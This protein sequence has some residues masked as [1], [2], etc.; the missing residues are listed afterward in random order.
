MNEQKLKELLHLYVLGELTGKEKEIIENHL[1][2]SDEYKEEYE[3]LKKFYETVSA[4]KPAKVADSLLFEA[5]AGLR[6]KLTGME[7]KE[8]LFA[9]IGEGLTNFFTAPF[10]PAYSAAL[11]L[12]LGLF[13]GYFMFSSSPRVDVLPQQEG[14]E[15]NLDEIERSGMNISN[16]R[17]R[18]SF[19]NGGDIEI[20]FDA[21]KPISMKGNMEDVRI[22]RLLAAALT[23]SENDGVRIRTVNTIASR[24]NENFIA[25][26][27]IKVALIMAL[28]TDKNVGVRREAL[29]T[30]KK[31]PYDTELRDAYLFALTNDTNPGIKVAA[32]NALAELKMQGKSIDNE[33]K[34]VLENE[35][36]DGQEDYIKLRAASLI[37]EV[38]QNE[39]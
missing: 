25:D 4:N 22:Q 15:V 11:T 14:K 36:D 38:K 9:K 35:F 16:I 10:A 21:I 13:I 23:S 1:L 5:R 2:E 33:L 20:T 6:R 29:N 12:L 39:N 24:T 31:F 37:R 27:K 30:L 17:F 28:K 8:S 19:S 26:P 32:I 18:D 7:K 3:Q 34:Q